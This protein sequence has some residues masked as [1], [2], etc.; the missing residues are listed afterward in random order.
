MAARHKASHHQGKRAGREQA[1]DAALEDS[2]PASDPIAATQPAPA[3]D[4]QGVGALQIKRHDKGDVVELSD[5]SRWRIWPEDASN[6]LG[7]Q[8]NTG[9]R[10]VEID[11]EFCSHALVNPGDKSRTRVIEASRAWP[12]EEVRKSLKGR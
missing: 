8:R 4:D 3:A 10:V 11:D 5:G 12:V 1:L 6:A 9:L 2:F 7:W